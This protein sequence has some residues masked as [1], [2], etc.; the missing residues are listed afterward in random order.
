MTGRSTS[1]SGELRALRNELYLKL[2][3]FGLAGTMK[4]GAKRVLARAQGWLSGRTA[5][6]DAFDSEHGT[7]TSG[8]VPVGAL[9]LPADR[10]GHA[11]RYPTGIVTVF[12]EM[13]A[14]LPGPH[15]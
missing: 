3:Q 12:L 6:V 1:G 11:V 10:L 2:R 9:D 14:A 13:L 7:D 4:L 8:I 15:G 5:S